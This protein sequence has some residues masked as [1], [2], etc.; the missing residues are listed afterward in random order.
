MVLFWEP[1]VI[2]LTLNIYPVGRNKLH[3]KNHELRTLYSSLTRIRC[4]YLL[5]Y[6]LL[7]LSPKA[8]ERVPVH[9]GI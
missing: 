5:I 1:K 7:V 2:T 6:E 4:T 8:C 3:P 9:V